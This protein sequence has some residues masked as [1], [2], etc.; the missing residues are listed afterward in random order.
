M[1]LAYMQ[2]VLEGE[3]VTDFGPPPD[4]IVTRRIDPVTGLLAHPDT[5]DAL[6]ELFLDGTQPMRFTP[7]S[8]GPVPGDLWMQP[9]GT[10]DTAPPRQYDEF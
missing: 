7:Q 9:A 6:D 1:W 5:P 4:G 10:A 3:P 2:T 8:I